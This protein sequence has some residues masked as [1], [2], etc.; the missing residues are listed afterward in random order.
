MYVSRYANFQTIFLTYH[1][2]SLDQSSHWL[3][4]R[5]NLD[6]I[7]ISNTWC[8]SGVPWRCNLLFTRILNLL[9]FSL[10]PAGHLDFSFAVVCWRVNLIYLAGCLPR[11]SSWFFHGLLLLMLNVEQSSALLCINNDSLEVSCVKWVCVGK[12]GHK[13]TEC[14]AQHTRFKRGLLDM[15]EQVHV[16]SRECVCSLR[17]LTVLVEFTYMS[18]S[19]THYQQFVLVIIWSWKPS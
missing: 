1:P 12:W 4:S 7:R 11:S 9:N 18:P 19:S 2:T 10:L 16:L 5:G 6:R 14:S 15:K 13:V 3:L 17:V 8:L